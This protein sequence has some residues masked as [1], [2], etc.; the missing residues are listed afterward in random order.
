M[1]RASLIS[2]CLIL[3]FAGSVFGC[4]AGFGE[5][6]AP[7]CSESGK[8]RMCARKQAGSTA[9]SGSAWREIMK[10]P[11][12]Q[13]SLRSLTQGQVAE[14]SRFEIP[15]PLRMTKGRSTAQPKSLLIIASIGSPETDRGPPRS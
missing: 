14:F 1:R 12:S 8:D 13:C 7:R 10:S 6:R 9:M 2:A 11:P 15:T 4:V 3:M 5:E